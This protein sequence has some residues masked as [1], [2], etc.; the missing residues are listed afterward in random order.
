MNQVYEEVIQILESTTQNETVECRTKL[1]LSGAKYLSQE[2]ILSELVSL[3]SSCDPDL[4]VSASNLISKYSKTL[5]DFKSVCRE[6]VILVLDPELLGF[7]WESL[8]CVAAS[9]QAMSRL[10][11][12][13]YLAT[14]WR[15]HAKD[16]TSTVNEGIANDS[17]FY[18][19]NPDKSLPKTQERLEGVLKG[20]KEWEGLTGEKPKPGQQAEVL[21][22][23]DAYIYA[24]HGGG[25][26]MTNEEIKKLRIRSVPILLGCR[27]VEL[28]RLGRNLDPLGVVHSY[29]VGSSPAIA[30][31]LWPVS[32]AD[33]D[34]W[35]IE[36]LKYWVSGQEKNLLQ[37]VADQRSNFNHLV[38][39]A[40]LVVYGFPISIKSK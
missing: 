12:L 24:G 6:P 10:P 38:N 25:T 15:F 33:L 27:S 7:P 23:K 4:V 1:I 17:I 3:F 9:K 13:Q 16:S 22:K 34:Q 19:L 21:S 5:L 29:L 40:G 20:F 2:Q 11:S 28:V 31:F 35:T 26:F 36:F 30:G 14:M 39:S 32:D 37:A 8:P 18:I